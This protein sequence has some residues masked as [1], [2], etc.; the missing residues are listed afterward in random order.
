MYYIV[1]LD[2]YYYIYFC[3]NI[4]TSEVFFKMD[5]FTNQSTRDNTKKYIRD[6]YYYYIQQCPLFSKTV[7]YN[8]ALSSARTV[9]C[10][11]ADFSYCI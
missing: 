7:Q 6:N 9:D 2:N 5:S 1:L 3:F 8:P 4:F 10:N 11:L